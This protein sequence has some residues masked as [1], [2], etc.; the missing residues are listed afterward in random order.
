MVIDG[1]TTVVLYGDHG[2]RHETAIVLG[3]KSKISLFEGDKTTFKS[4]VKGDSLI[5]NYVTKH[6]TVI[7]V[8]DDLLVYLL[9][10][11][12]PHSR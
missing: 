9:G 11:F 10:T 6:K 8:G 2:Q 4:K 5:L 12:H 3:K 7:R 1:T